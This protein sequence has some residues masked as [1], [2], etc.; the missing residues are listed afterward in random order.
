[1][2][3]GRTWWLILLCAGVSARAQEFSLEDL[4][5]E[6]DIRVVTN[7]DL[8]AVSEVIGVTESDLKQWGRDMQEE[9][10]R[11]FELDL[12]P[13]DGWLGRFEAPQP[14]LELPPPP[15]VPPM[16][17]EF[18]LAPNPLP[19]ATKR[20][21]LVAE[22]KLVFLSQGVPPQLVWIAEVESSFNPKAKSRVGAAGLFQIMPETAFLLG[23][24][25]EPEDERLDPVKSA[26]AA[27]EY[28][29]YLYGKFRDWRLVMAAYNGGEGRVRRLLDKSRSKTF[30]A[31]ALQLPLETQLYVPKIEAAILRNEGKLLGALPATR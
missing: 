16:V 14:K 27:A 4:F 24:S 2:R 12:S 26:R 20:A 15:P 23:L 8:K 13:L 17:P 30:E 29:R 5:G 1:M 21:A 19:L 3:T 28:L 6:L 9:L 18:K 22:L 11:E 25:L 10:S 31:I 7:L